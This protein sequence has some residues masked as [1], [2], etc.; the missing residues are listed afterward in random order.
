M[1]GE[2]VLL[3]NSSPEKADSALRPPDGKRGGEEGGKPGA[4]PGPLGAPLAA[5]TRTASCP[6]QRTDV[7]LSN[8][9]TDASHRAFV[10]VWVSLLLQTGRPGEP[11]PNGHSAPRPC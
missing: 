9:S 6:K 3:E 2:A 7:S 8:R 4:V 1:T 5:E 11:D 10:W